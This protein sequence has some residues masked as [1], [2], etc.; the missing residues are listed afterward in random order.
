MQPWLDG[1]YGVVV[2]CQLDG[3]AGPNGVRM[4]LDLRCHPGW[5]WHTKYLGD[6][7]GKG[8]LAHPLHANDALEGEDAVVLVLVELGVI[9]QV[10]GRDEQLASSSGFVATA[11]S[12]ASHNNQQPP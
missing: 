1:T 10:A 6:E 8:G 12:C 2:E 3:V 4:T 9:A 7:V 11:I 5:Q